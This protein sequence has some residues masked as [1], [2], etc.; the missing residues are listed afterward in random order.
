[1]LSVN[2]VHKAHWILQRLATELTDNIPGVR[3][4][5]GG[6]PPR[7]PSDADVQYFLPGRNIRHC[8]TPPKGILVGFFT[9]GDHHVATY[10]HRFQVC[11]A[12]N[13]RMATLLRQAGAKDVR[14]FR[15]GTDATTRPIVFGVCARSVESHGPKTR[16]GL[17]LVAAAVRA[18][19]TFVA[20]SPD[21]AEVWPCPITHRTEDRAAFY[22]S[23]DY[24]V[25]T[26]RDEGGPMTVPEAISHGVPVIAP[27][28]GWAWEFPVIRYERG[29]PGLSRVLSDLTQPPTWTQWVSDHR[30]LFAELEARRR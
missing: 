19:H 8:P 4:N 28:V 16:K 23:I 10:W 3:L 22:A 17:D 18:G 29:W 15:P 7:V 5:D 30:A 14:V 11:L 1:M 24:L 21:Q 2:V 12:M 26:S 25:V 27:D 20:C 6:W 9:H 13:Q